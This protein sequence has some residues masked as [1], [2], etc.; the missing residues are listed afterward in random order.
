MIDTQR[1]TRL[2]GIDSQEHPARYNHP[3]FLNRQ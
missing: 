2:C 3:S 1:Q